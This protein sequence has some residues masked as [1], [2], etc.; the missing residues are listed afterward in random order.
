VEH[1]E[2]FQYFGDFQGVVRENS[3]RLI[4][5]NINGIPPKADHPKNVM[6]KA[7]IT[8]SGASITGLAETNL[9]WSKLKGK[10]RWEERSLGWWED[11]SSITCH[12]K[13]DQPKKDFQ[14][15]G[16]LMITTGQAKYRMVKSGVD[17]SNM[18]RWCWQSFSGKTGVITK[19][20][21][22][23][24]PCK[25]NGL[26]S[27]YMQQQRILDA[28][29]KTTCPRKEMLDDLTTAITTWLSEGE[30][31]I[32]M[33]DLNDNCD[34]SEA[35]D[36]LTSI[37]LKECI[38]NR[39][40]EQPPA[41]CNRGTKPIDGIYASNTILIEKGGYCPFNLFPT[42]HRA[43]W[44]DLTM[45]NLCG[46]NMAPILHPQARR[47]KCN[48]PPTQAKWTKLYL[49]F[50]NKRNAINRSYSLQENL[51][52]PLTEQHIIEYEKLHRIRKDALLYADK[53]CR[54]LRMGG[55]PFSIELTKARTEIEMWK[56]ITSW[57]LGRKVN[58]KHILINNEWTR[59]NPA[60]VTTR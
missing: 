41:T 8:K 12:N 10:H 49:D 45:S 25:S 57:K 19:V 4:F 40:Q 50:L 44:I 35:N 55:V 7:A 52:C 36:R 5:A 16:N 17:P 42:D 60:R 6:L 24:R 1:E 32:L 9:S 29:N 28:R 22:A 43:L 56:A 14:P 59:L 3:I 23:Y 11:M 46:N 20:I 54:K 47:L 31:I 48:D 30:Q 27:T 34:H 37:G 13:L 33:L 53:K 18:G 58:T 21:T 2:N 51:T 15:G 39:H 38:L 26:M